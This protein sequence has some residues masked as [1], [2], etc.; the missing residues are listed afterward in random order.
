MP[1]KH[2]FHYS[3]YKINKKKA[4]GCIVKFSSFKLNFS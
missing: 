2:I 4:T 1:A 3:Y